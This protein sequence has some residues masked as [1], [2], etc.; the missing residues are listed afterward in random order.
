ML[1]HN[2]CIVSIQS[3]NHLHTKFLKGFSLRGGWLL[4]KAWQGMNKLP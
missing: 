2:G 1:D 4:S 3:K